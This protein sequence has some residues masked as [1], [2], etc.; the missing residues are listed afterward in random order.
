MNAIAMSKLVLAAAGATFAVSTLA[1][2]A[3]AQS[4]PSSTPAPSRF[5]NLKVLPAD[6]SQGDLRAT[7]KGFAQ[8]LGVRCTFCHVGV[9]GQPLST[10]DFAADT[11]PHKNVA[12]A[13]LRMTMRLNQELPVASGHKDAKVTCYTCHRGAKEPATEIPE[14]PPPVTPAG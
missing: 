14:A 10:F 3:M 12:R 6:I 7:M 2:I 8:G 13:M 5:K 11:N 9:E 4:T 1:G